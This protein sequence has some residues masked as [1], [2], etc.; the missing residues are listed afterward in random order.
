MPVAEVVV[1]GVEE[2]MFIPDAPDGDEVEELEQAAMA[3]AATAA[4]AAADSRRETREVRMKDAAFHEC[5]HRR[6]GR[7]G[8]F[9]PPGDP[10]GVRASIT[11][12]RS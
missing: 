12:L 9:A 5:A 10:G 8:T 6:A 7:T 4:R 2:D 3:D 11:V 1:V